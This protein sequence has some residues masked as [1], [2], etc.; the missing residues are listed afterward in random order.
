MN[1]WLFWFLFIRPLSQRPSIMPRST[2]PPRKRSR[3]TATP[4]SSPKAPSPKT[5]RKPRSRKTASTQPA[6]PPTAPPSRSGW[7]IILA[8]VLAAV[9]YR[10]RDQIP[11]PSIAE[12]PDT[13]LARDAV[14]HHSQLLISEIIEPLR[15][16]NDGTL[17]NDACLDLLK[18]AHPVID[19]HTW[20]PLANRLRELQSR[21]AQGQPTGLMDQSALARFLDDCEA[22]IE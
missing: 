21:D 15:K 12:S 19:R 5:P 6:F 1:A 8:I 18:T 13:I 2:D 22:G 14:T 9:A 17:K 4:E 16:L 7:I 20:T 11:R 10:Y 3:G